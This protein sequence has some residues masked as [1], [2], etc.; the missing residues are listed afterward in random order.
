M[1][2]RP[3]AV[4]VIDDKVWVVRTSEGQPRH[5]RREETY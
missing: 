4:C 1:I 5:V 2:G 3:R